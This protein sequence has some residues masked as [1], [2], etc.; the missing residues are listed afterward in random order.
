MREKLASKLSLYGMAMS[1]I[2]LVSCSE[3]SLIWTFQYMGLFFILS[4]AVSIFENLAELGLVMPKKIIKV[5][6]EKK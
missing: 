1:T 4:E 5:L 6:G 3:E 2:Y